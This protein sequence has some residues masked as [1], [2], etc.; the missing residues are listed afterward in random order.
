MMH[1][2]ATE[3]HYVY[4]VQWGISYLPICPVLHTTGCPKPEVHKS[5]VLHHPVKQD[6]HDGA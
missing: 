5:W 6:L 1:T 2:K 3:A 4:K